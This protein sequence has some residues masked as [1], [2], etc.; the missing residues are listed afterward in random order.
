VSSLELAG[1]A[2]AAMRAARSN[3][4]SMVLLISAIGSCPPQNMCR[5]TS[6]LYDKSGR[7]TTG[8]LLAFIGAAMGNG[9]CL[10]TTA[11]LA[12]AITVQEDL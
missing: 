10:K 2:V 7:L 6:R 1:S 8:D 11:H 4:I 9:V 3:T 5:S 12:A